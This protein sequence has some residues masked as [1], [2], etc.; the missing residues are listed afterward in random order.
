MWSKS[1]S[2]V[3]VCALFLKPSSPRRPESQIA[4]FAICANRLVVSP[5]GGAALSCAVTEGVLTLVFAL[6]LQSLK[7]RQRSTLLQS[8][9]KERQA[10][11]LIE[12]AF[13]T[14]RSSSKSW[15]FFQSF[16]NSPLLNL[17]LSPS[18]AS[19]HSMSAVNRLCRSGILLII[20][21]NKFG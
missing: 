18:G 15:F 20:F 10:S 14:Q 3:V 1:E 7:S 6:W 16:A 5:R 19:F 8:W 17:N 21:K 13:K 2:R 4:V 11:P 12:G 9:R